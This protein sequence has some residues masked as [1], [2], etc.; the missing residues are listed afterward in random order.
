MSATL[1]GR[2]RRRDGSRPCTFVPS[3]L[4]IEEDERMHLRER[5]H[6]LAAIDE[7]LV[8]GGML[9][10]E[11]PAGIGKTS[12]ADEAA[13][14]APA[15]GR[16][17]LLARGSLLEAAFP[18]GMARQLFEPLLRGHCAGSLLSG[19]ARGAVSAI[20]LEGAEA[21]AD[22]SGFEALRGLA[23][24]TANAAESGPLLLVLDDVQW[25]DGPSLRFAGFLARRLDGP[26]IAVCT[27]IRSG[28]PGAPERLLDELRGAPGA[29]RLTP[30]PLSESA[31][32]ELVR[33]RDPGAEDLVC[34]RCHD[35]TRGNPLLVAEVLRA[36][37]GGD[38]AVRAA[39]AGIGGGVRRRIDRADPSALRVACAAAV[40]GEDATLG[41]VVAL[42]GLDP[43]DA[44]RAASA[45]AVASV[46]NGAVPYT[47]T[48][49][50][51]RS[52]VLETLDDGERM[53]LHRVAAQALGAEG[54]AGERVAAHLLATPGT[55]DL[56]TLARLRDAAAAALTRGG[57][58][59]AVPLLK[60]ALAEPPP[61]DARCAVLRELGAAERLTGEGAS[62][63]HLRAAQTLAIAPEERAALAHEL[64]MAQYDL[65]YY[66]DTAQTLSAALQEAP[67]DLDAHSRDDL[68]VDL[69]TVALLVSSLDREQL[70]ADFRRGA[71]PADPMVLVA[72]EIASTGLQLAE[73]RSVPGAARQSEALL[74]ANPPSRERLDIHTPIWFALQACERFDGLRDMLDAVEHGT[75]PGWTRRQFA[76]NLARGHLEHRLGNL[77]AAASVHE[78]NLEFGIDNVT[79]VLYT[80]AGLASVCIDR[81]EIDRATGLLESI[82][83]PPSMNELHLA[84]V[85]T[86]IGRVAAAAGDDEA[87]ARSF[88][89][90]CA[91]HRAVPGA[92]DVIWESGGS[93][94]VACFVRQ[95]RL[96]E[97]RVDVARTLA[98]AREAELIGL[99]GTALRMRGLVDGDRASLEGS[100]ACLARTPMRLE[101]A[102]SLCE[103]GAHLR[104]A[105]E[106][107]AARD[108]LRSALGLAHACG[109]QP[110][111]KRAREE[112]QLAGARPRRDA[113]SG[114]DSLTAAELR[115][116]R[117]A[118][119]G[120]GNRAVAQE[121]F[122]T[123]KTVEGHLARTFRKLDVQRRE[124]L[125]SALEAAA[126]TTL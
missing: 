46:L 49:P 66:A 108:P 1:T 53:D 112:L 72:L 89:T 87:A 24:L 113:Q 83:V 86:A 42:S 123:T 114:R 22:P 36:M 93:D 30:S 63:G 121:L 125:S 81:G 44:G 60:R 76:I 122:I 94:R 117:L 50:L 82:D 58:S 28:E 68:R 3:T 4:A 77:D 92:A 35:A 61:A 6:E 54:A 65:G 29:R 38:D 110:L 120:L 126:P 80:L 39:A 12:L 47:F 48:H 37:D 116:A 52:A 104:R 69:L 11:G 23:A 70:L 19:V 31:T 90:A 75:D 111:A 7:L 14:R 57:A 40:L 119:K 26:D 95:G 85:H 106:R 41:H 124:D 84:W 9:V 15:A 59:S 118:A 25:S 109:A 102:H 2:D 78:A 27:T 71:P 33:E 97:A 79:G 13:T 55:G 43:R 98:V 10:V 32:A 67:E 107:T 8:G 74:A 101:H 115:V 62:I 20:G 45:L 105:G 103:L 16:R 88:E 73:A 64:A 21:T 56:A 18:F 5:E 51:V 91:I 100:V 96:E 17:A 99:E 34:T